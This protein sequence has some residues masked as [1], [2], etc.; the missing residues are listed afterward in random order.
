M[1][2]D[3]Y[4]AAVRNEFDRLEGSVPYGVCYQVPLET[5][6]S[7]VDAEAGAAFYARWRDTD[8]VD[9]STATD[10]R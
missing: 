6:R 8:V 9:R 5:L 1:V 3:D 2:N 4:N 7:L 10:L